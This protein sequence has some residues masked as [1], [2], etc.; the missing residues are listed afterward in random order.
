MTVT[1]TV[2]VGVLALQ[3]A[4]IEHE[5]HLEK[6]F[7]NLNGQHGICL[8]VSTVNDFLIYHVL[9][10]VAYGLIMSTNLR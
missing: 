5:R 7:A 2:R 10:K 4:F 8:S 9:L 3:G 6:A 1:K